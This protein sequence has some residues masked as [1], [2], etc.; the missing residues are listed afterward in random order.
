M[1]ERLDTECGDAKKSPISVFVPL[2][3]TLIICAV[4]LLSALD[5][6]YGSG[7]LGCILMMLSSGALATLIL[8]GGVFVPI[9]NVAVSL[10]V[11][12]LASGLQ[13]IAP[14]IGAGYLLLGFLI[15]KFAKY[16]IPRSSAVVRT[17]FAMLFYILAVGAICYAVNGHSLA[18]KALLTDLDGI[19]N[20]IK[21]DR[22]AKMMG[23][24]DAIPDSLLALYERLGFT[25]EMLLEAQILSTEAAVDRLEMLFPGLVIAAAQIVA[26]LITTL[27]CFI[28]LRVHADI[29][30]EEPMWALCPRQVSCVLYM[31]TA[32]LYLLTSFFGDGSI[33]AIIVT[34]LLLMLLPSMAACGVRELIARLKNPKKRG[35]ALAVLALFVFGC[36][37]MTSAVLP[38]AMVLLG[39]LG[40]KTVS[41]VWIL[42]AEKSKKEK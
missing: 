14:V 26:Y 18:P 20:S 28:M 30:V 9:F 19:F 27:S 16:G 12:Y 2:W 37:F 6:G 31:I 5:F 24:A 38:I 1:T 11:L 4:S 34:N 17:A 36:L 29:M 35:Q 41:V 21:L 8:I 33:F 23:T 42:A 7:I 22:V 32:V 40:A 25:R 15:S 3:M 13:Y 39:F 10:L